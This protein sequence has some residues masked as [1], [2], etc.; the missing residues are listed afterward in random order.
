MADYSKL[1]LAD[2]LICVGGKTGMGVTSFTLRMAQHLSF[3][4]RVLFISYH[5]YAENLSEKLGKGTYSDKDLT[6]EDSLP[7][8]DSEFCENMTPW[9][10]EE[11]YD[12]VIFDDLNSLCGKVYAGDYYMPEDVISGFGEIASELNIRIVANLTLGAAGED[13]NVAKPSLR[14][15]TWARNIIHESDQ[16]IALHRPFHYGILEDENGNSTVN[17]MEILYLK[18]LQN[19]PGMLVLSDWH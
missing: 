18:D 12:T 16:I 10:D 13:N 17:N 8:F 5:D 2:G 9:L 6:I 7:F 15:F 19:K 4:E 1:S 3:Y 14:D 11:G